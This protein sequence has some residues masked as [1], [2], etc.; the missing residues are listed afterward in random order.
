MPKDLPIYLN[1]VSVRYKLEITEHM[2]EMSIWY[3]ML[4]E[5]KQNPP[6]SMSF[7]LV[8]KKGRELQFT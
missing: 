5:E 6:K 7:V 4:K 3:I 2:E 8:S 1:Q